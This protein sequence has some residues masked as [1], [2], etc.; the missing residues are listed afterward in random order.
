MPG[1]S[2]S[3]DDDGRVATQIGIVVVV[4]LFRARGLHGVALLG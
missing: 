3:S 2:G 1:P 4:G